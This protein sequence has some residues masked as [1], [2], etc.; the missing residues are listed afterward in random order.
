MQKILIIDDELFFREFVTDNLKKAGYEP[1]SASSGAEGLRILERE[2][3]EIS[4]ILLDIIMPEMDGLAT[5]EKI[6]EID[7]ELPV[8]MMTA[9]TDEQLV[10]MAL[11]K[12]AFDYLAKPLYIDELLL[13][14][15]RAGDHYRLVVENKRKL[16][17]LKN[18]E[19]GAQRLVE[20]IK[21]SIRME[22]IVKNNSLLQ[23]TID[24][25][26]SVIEAEKVSMM[27]VDEEKKELRVV[28]ANGRDV[29]VSTFPARKIGEGIAGTVAEK[30]E[31]I[32]VKDIKDSGKVK[33]SGFAK[34][35]KT[36][37]FLCV[38]VKVLGK[39]IGVISVNDKR[40]G[41]SFTE[42]DQF[43]VT[44]FSYQVTLALENAMISADMERYIEKLTLL[45]DI[46]KTLLYMVNPTDIFRDIAKR[47]KEILEV[48]VCAIMLTEETTGELRYEICLGEKGEITS[49]D[50]IKPGEGITGEVLKTGK[51]TCID[52]V[53]IDK[54]YLPKADGFQGIQVRGMICAPLKIKDQT[55]GVIKAVNKKGGQVCTV[56]DKELMESIASQSS[57]ALKNAWLYKNLESTV[58]EVA[59]TN[60]ELERVRAEL[61]QL[62]KGRG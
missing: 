26:S 34:Q 44:T 29:D 50:T 14:M 1:L 61:E 59:T 51:M 55:L 30:G 54:R 19:T 12:G 31:A 18:L 7:P 3:E 40:T 48:E 27:L 5:L 42:S 23:T 56:R 62:K 41:E 15:K 39:T 46:S 17:Q 24:L 28:V 35:Y 11:K 25:I 21:G 45:N 49:K 8:V 58:D 38:P 10:L 47:T 60:V 32:L 43:I 2:K 13:S 6:K 4:A 16:K 57:I 53:S 33:E 20:L 9:H 52:N 36:G 37:S 22:V